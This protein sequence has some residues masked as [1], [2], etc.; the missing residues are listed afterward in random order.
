MR[1]FGR[2]RFNE[3]ICR[4]NIGPV[5]VIESRVIMRVPVL[6]I[7]VFSGR[8]SPTRTRTRKYFN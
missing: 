3:R 8:V 1:G 7:T 6:G 5:V 4:V 2:E